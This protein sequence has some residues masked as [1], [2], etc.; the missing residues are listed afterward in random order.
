[1]KRALDNM[2]TIDKI[3]KLKNQ[4]LPSRNQLNKNFGSRSTSNLAWENKESQNSIDKNA[5]LLGK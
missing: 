3:P 2:G 5:N 1:M 4:Y